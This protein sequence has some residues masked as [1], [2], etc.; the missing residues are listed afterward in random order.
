MRALR[1]PTVAYLLGLFRACLFY[2]GLCQ[3]FHESLPDRF[4]LEIL[5]RHLTPLGKGLCATRAGDEFLEQD[6]QYPNDLPDFGQWQGKT[7]DR[8]CLVE[9]DSQYPRRQARDGPDAI[10]L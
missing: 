10:R 2:R 7:S 8:R 4:R 3:R 9:Q 1:G 5:K 6:S